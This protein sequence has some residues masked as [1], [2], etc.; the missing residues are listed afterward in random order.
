M[1]DEPDNN[2]N[3]RTEECCDDEKALRTE[4]DSMPE[5]GTFANDQDVAMAEEPSTNAQP[6]GES[7]DDT[8]SSTSEEVSGT[9]SDQ[10]ANISSNGGYSG[11]YESIS[12]SSSGASKKRNS[13]NLTAKAG[14]SAGER[15]RRDEEDKKDEAAANAMEDMNAAEDDDHQVDAKQ[16]AIG[17]NTSVHH[18]HHYHHTNRPNKSNS[19]QVNRQIDEIMNL[20]N[21]SL[22]AQ[23]NAQPAMRGDATNNGKM[24]ADTANDTS[25]AGDSTLNE[26]RKQNN[27]RVH[28]PF[29]VE[30]MGSL[31]EDH[32]HP[33]QRS[34]V[35]SMSS[36]NKN[37]TFANDLKGPVQLGGVRIMDPSDPRVDVTRLYHQDQSGCPK[38]D[39]AKAEGSHTN[40]DSDVNAHESSS[41]NMDDCYNNLLEA[42]RPFFQDSQTIMKSRKVPMFPTATH[43]SLAGSDEAQSSSGFTSFFTTTKSESNTNG[44]SG[45]S[46]QSEFSQ[47]NKKRKSEEKQ[48]QDE[49][50][51]STSLPENVPRS[52]HNRS[53]NALH[54]HHH[55]Q[56]QNQH[57]QQGGAGISR[58]RSHSGSHLEAYQSDS[59]SMVVLARVKRKHKEQ[60][61]N[62][63][64]NNS[65]NTA[66][67]VCA[68]SSSASGQAA[69]S[70][71][72]KRDG[73][74][75][76][77]V[78]KRV[79][80][81][82]VALDAAK[83]R[84]SNKP[85]LQPNS[86]QPES[87][88]LSSG[89]STSVDSSGS[90]GGGG[91]VG[92]AQTKRHDGA[93][94]GT[95]TTSVEDRSKTDSQSGSAEN[96]NNQAVRTVTDTSGTTTANNS[97]GSGTGSGNDNDATNKSE[98]GSQMEGNS[99]SDDKA[100]AYCEKDSMSD[101]NTNTS[102]A[103]VYGDG[104]KK[105]EIPL[106]SEKPMIHY[107][108]HGGKKAP[109]VD[110]LPQEEPEPMMDEPEMPN[111]NN[112]VI[113]KEEKLMEKKRKRMSA[114][115]EYE[116]E[117]QRQMR[118]S[119]E[120]SARND[121]S[122]LEPGKPV[123]LEDVLSFTKTARYVDSSDV[124]SWNIHICTAH[125]IF[126][127]HTGCL[128]RHCLL[129]LP[130]TP[131]LPLLSSQAS[132]LT[133][134]LGS[135]WRRSLQLQ[136]VCPQ[137]RRVIRQDRT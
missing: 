102:V 122:T 62:G 43:Q 95:T 76:E 125:H 19:K 58:T 41:H 123:T 67:A 117:W 32:K 10:T 52:D 73:E 40:I 88:S 34:S 103:A 129:S 54:H 2:V 113:T 51:D 127:C 107:H 71:Q 85:L 132:T 6:P 9:Q 59:S 4:N 114:R 131:T 64:S 17:N 37:S 70:A 96:S 36:N 121:T 79:R 74:V 83:Y 81:E 63:S 90:D 14:S 27:S 31:T 57:Q 133:Q 21:V 47:Q 3:R 44:G 20:Y 33:P 100:G 38:D 82:T 8:L 112:N 72:G 101:T 104:K 48:E 29:Q 97:S 16:H 26:M 92:G 24:E 94:A 105:V 120:S 89:L 23:A 28:Y 1:S 115:K 98:S 11:D 86:K 118:D 45:G 18:H 108:N 60:Q 12:D 128:C 30:S 99:N 66:K 13:R 137:T 116:E 119:S 91:G 136:K 126:P 110:N 53:E 77:N 7:M 15:H 106:Q 50:K 130:F 46:S 42:C 56:Q 39:S 109:M 35:G 25:M 69:S 134:L 22:Q 93:H 135:L 87:S 75:E 84:S 65:D 61:R 5:N 78:S 111:S 55:Q 124:G 68:V 49:P 80:I